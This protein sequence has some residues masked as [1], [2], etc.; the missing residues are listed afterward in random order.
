MNT[1]DPIALIRRDRTEARK[2]DDANADICFLALADNEGRASART[3]VLRDITDNRFM[4]FINQSS[5][6]WRV[7]EAGGSW[8]L[9]LWYPSMQR[10][11]RV[12]G[13]TSPVDMDF[14]RQSWRRRPTGSKYLDVFYE[15]TADQSSEYESREMLVQEIHRIR[16]E[17]NEDEMEAPTK[18][19]GVLLVATRIEMLDLNREDRIHDRQLYVLEE[20]G[21]TSKT[22]VP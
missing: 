4:L 17:F 13:A 8:E 14:V 22:L 6:K 7:L 3:L 10:Q 19:A 21:W 2:L 9:L 16:D 5:P 12:S 20:G 15:F 18:V 11:Y 1:I